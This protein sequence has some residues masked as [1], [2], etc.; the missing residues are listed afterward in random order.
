MNQ[1]VYSTGINP[2]ITLHEVEEFA[3]KRVDGQTIEQLC[4]Q[5]GMGDIES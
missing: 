4:E 3:L 2:V 5:I 1:L